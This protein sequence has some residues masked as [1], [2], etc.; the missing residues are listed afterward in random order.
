MPLSELQYYPDLS[1][2]HIFNFCHFIS[3]S[4][5]ITEENLQS[6]ITEIERELEEAKRSAEPTEG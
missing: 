2:W 4:K 6:V 5:M 3:F 1:S